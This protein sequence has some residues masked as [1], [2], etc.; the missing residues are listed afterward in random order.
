MRAITDGD[1][2][3]ACHRLCDEIGRDA[4]SLSGRNNIRRM[5]SHGNSQCQRNVCDTA[6]GHLP[7]G[8][9]LPD[10]IFPPSVTSDS[11]L[12]LLSKQVS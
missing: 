10:R 1:T 3:P 7:S 6:T 8:R 11:W 4:R 2:R 5:M 9:P 12:E